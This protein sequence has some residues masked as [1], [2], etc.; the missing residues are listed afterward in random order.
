M[1]RRLGDTSAKRVPPTGSRK[2]RRQRIRARREIIALTATQNRRR[3]AAKR[4][5]PDSVVSFRV[6]LALQ[7][8]GSNVGQI[9]PVNGGGRVRG[10]AW[11]QGAMS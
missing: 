4:S 3:T 8:R 7:E 11:R 2:S 9:D 5:R 10:A 6:L 1:D